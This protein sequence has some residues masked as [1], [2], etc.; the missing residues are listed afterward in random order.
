[1][2]HKIELQSLRGLSALTAGN[3]LKQEGIGWWWW[4]S[5]YGT[6]ALCSF[7]AAFISVLFSAF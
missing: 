5:V 3:R 6:G 7:V 2:T 1:M 4:S